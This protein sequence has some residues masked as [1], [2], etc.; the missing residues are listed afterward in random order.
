MFHPQVSPS[1]S[2]IVLLCVLC[3]HETQDPFTV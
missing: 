1:L 2:D 3:M